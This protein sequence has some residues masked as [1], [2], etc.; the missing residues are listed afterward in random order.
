MAR[1]AVHGRGLAQGVD[2]LNRAGLLDQKAPP[3]HLADLRRA[4]H[5]PGEQPGL[6]DAPVEGAGVAA[7]RLQAECRGGVRRV[8]QALGVKHGQG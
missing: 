7:D 8:G 1:G 3:D 2:V 6:V 4:D 5:L